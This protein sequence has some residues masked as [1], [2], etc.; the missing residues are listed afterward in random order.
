MNTTFILPGVI[1]IPNTTI[2]QLHFTE[3]NS[4]VNQVYE[5]QLIQPIKNTN[6]LY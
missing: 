4:S 6:D 1:A 5:S 3:W 2:I